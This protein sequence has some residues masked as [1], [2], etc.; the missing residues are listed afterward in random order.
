MRYLVLSLFSCT[1]N[2]TI[3]LPDVKFSAFYQKAAGIVKLGFDP[4]H[5]KSMRS[6]ILPSRGCTQIKAEKVRSV[7]IA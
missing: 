1:V 4:K 2:T 3:S 7:T 5:V 6:I